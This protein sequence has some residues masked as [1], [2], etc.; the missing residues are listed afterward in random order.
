[1]ALSSSSLSE[2]EAL[3]ATCLVQ[4]GL[5]SRSLESSK[6]V[7]EHTRSA[8]QGGVEL[9]DIHLS[10][11]ESVQNLLL[12][13]T[14]PEFILTQ[15]LSASIMDL[16]ALRYINRFAVAKGVPT[17][18]K[19]SYA[20]LAEKIVVDVS[21]LKRVLRYAM[22]KGIFVEVDGEV[23][24]TETSLL[25][26]QDGIAT[27]SKYSSDRGWPIASCFNDS[28]DKWGH[29]SQEPNETAF[30][31]FKDTDLSMFE[32][33]EQH[34]AFGADF[35]A[36]MNQFTKSPP[37]SHEHI[38]SA[39]EWSSLSHAI[40]VDVGGSLGHGSIAILET[41]PTLTCIVQDL[42][43]TV[44]RATD[45]SISIVPAHMKNR[46]SFQEHSFWDP[47]PVVAD[48]YFLRMIFH[49]W[50]NKYAKKILQ[51][52]L[53]GM[54]PGSKILIMDYVTL[55]YGTLKIGDERRMRVR[56]MQMMVMH[57]ALERDEGEWR[58]LFAETDPRLRLIKIRKPVGSALSLLEVVLDH[59]RDSV[60]QP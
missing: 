48:I 21:Q 53:V 24:H 1:M 19:I 39:F 42:P 55:P 13:V 6:L 59:R 3:A 49:D 12:M 15:G 60:V 37:L 50:A 28:I 54:R 51:A 47:Q 16:T 34:P 2:L 22:T 4:A 26:L 45:P 18:E 14:P 56:D 29:G 31:V 7:N 30:N 35:H 17:T 11:F 43:K 44:A 38:K 33:H 8:H 57:N 10:L 25:L 9:R 36:V 32:Y 40:I 46:I 41:N 27:L 5:F 58:R 20:A 23:A 52:L